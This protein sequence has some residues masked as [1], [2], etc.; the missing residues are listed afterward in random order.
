MMVN[1]MPMWFSIEE[2]TLISRLNFAPVSISKKVTEAKKNC[3]LLNKYFDGRN[4]VLVIDLMNNLE[5]MWSTQNDDKTKIALLLFLY[6]VLHGFDQGGKVDLED[7]GLVNDIDL[8]D[9]CDWGMK[10]YNHILKSLN[11]DI[12]AKAHEKKKKKKGSR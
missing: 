4:K 7:M 12:R 6:G 9:S 11:K 5:E 10:T 1:K 8:F 3:C 2:Y